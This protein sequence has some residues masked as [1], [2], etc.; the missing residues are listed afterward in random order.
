[1]RDITPK[2]THQS[3]TA[4]GL[5]GA[6]TRAHGAFQP[7]RHIHLH[8]GVWVT[9]MDK[10]ARTAVFEVSNA[11]ASHRHLP[12]ADTGSSQAFSAPQLCS[13]LITSRPMRWLVERGPCRART[14]YHGTQSAV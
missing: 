1:M 14:G 12:L 8:N 4:R 10:G 7:Q 6:C 5:A 13:H 3:G 9:L 11:S 2:P